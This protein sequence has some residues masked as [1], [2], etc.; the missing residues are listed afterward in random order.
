LNGIL[1]ILE[2]ADPT[3]AE[4]FIARWNQTINNWNNGILSTEFL[5]SDSSEEDRDFVQYD[6]FKAKYEQLLQDHQATIDEGYLS[7]GIGYT[8]SVN[9]FQEAS[10]KKRNFTFLCHLKGSHYS[11]I[12]VQSCD[13]CQSRIG[14]DKNLF[15]SI[16]RS[17]K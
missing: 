5:P 2:S 4:K 8:T 10:N 17:P 7:I 1:F 12:M 14:H 15:L 13:E 16:F 9:Q 11:K 3:A 6:S